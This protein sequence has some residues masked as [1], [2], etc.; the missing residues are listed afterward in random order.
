[1]SKTFYNYLPP[2]L[3]PCERLNNAKKLIFDTKDGKG[4]G[5]QISCMTAGS[6]GVGRSDTYNFLH[7]S[8]FAWWQGDAMD[9][10]S[11]LMQS[12]PSTPDSIVI[13]ESTARG[14][15]HFKDMWDRAVAG[16]EDEEG[17]FIPVFFPWFEM[18]EY[19]KPYRGF[20]LNPEE[21]ELKAKYNLDNEQIAWRRWCIKNNCGGNIDIFRQEYPSNPY[22]AFVLTGQS[23]FDKDKINERLEDVEEPIKRGYFTYNKDVYYISNIQWVD[24]E[25]GPIKIYKDVEPRHPYVIGGD[26]AGEGSDYFTGQVIDNHTAQHVATLKQQIDED[27]YTEQMYCLGRYYNWALI[28]IEVNYSRYPNRLLHLMDYPHIYIRQREDTYME[29]LQKAYGFLT[30]QKTRPNM[31]AELVKIVRDEIDLINDKETLLEMSTFVRNDAGKAV[32]QVGKHDDLIMALAIAYYIRGQQQVELFD[33]DFIEEEKDEITRFID[34]FKPKTKGE[35]IE[36]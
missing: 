1:M 9:T 11:G 23:V 24:D 27:L 16:D 10:F 31:I 13:I 34:G 29:G 19:R 28:G 25:K 12:V 17:S 2:E 5:S 22:E 21:R 7:I 32:A 20:K 6:S 36:W 33:E 30:S 15:N 26:T 4:L 18:E 14:Y 3:K 8:E 35:Y